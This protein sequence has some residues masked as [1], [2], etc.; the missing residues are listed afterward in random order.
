MYFFL[1]LI[2]NTSH[3]AVAKVYLVYFH[4]LISKNDIKLKKILD[5][6]CD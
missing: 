4:Y 1:I 6:H 3:Y 2:Y 5:F